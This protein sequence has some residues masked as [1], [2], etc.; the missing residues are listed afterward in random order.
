MGISTQ[1]ASTFGLIFLLWEAAMR[2]AYT[3]LVKALEPAVIFVIY[4]LFAAFAAGAFLLMPRV[5][6]AKGKASICGK[7]GKAVGLW[8]DPKLWLLQLTNLTFGFAAA[9]NAS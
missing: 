9:W 8:A 1:L 5:R 2:A 4:G 7:A 3:G 6:E